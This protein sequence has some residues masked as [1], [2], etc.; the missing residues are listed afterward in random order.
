LPADAEVI[1]RVLDASGLDQA[2]MAANHNLPVTARAQV[3]AAPTT[4]AEKPV[5]VV[6][7]LA[8]PFRIEFTASDEVLRHGVNIEA[9]ITYG[10]AVRFRTVN[11]QVVT[12]SSIDRNP[13]EVWVMAVGR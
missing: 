1:V 8:L 2:R 12:L 3:A 10:G 4:L 13:Y 6:P 5:A 11:A 9:R 7:G